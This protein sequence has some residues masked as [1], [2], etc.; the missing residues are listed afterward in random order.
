MCSLM[1]CTDSVELALGS[2]QKR[3]SQELPLSIHACVAETCQS[4]TLDAHS[5][6]LT[7]GEFDSGYMCIRG[8]EQQVRLSFQRFPRTASELPVTLTIHAY[9]GTKLFEGQKTATIAPFYPNGYECDKNNP[10]YSGKVD[11]SSPSP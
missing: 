9:D 2:P 6:E 5:C 4:W 7:T 11:F 3:Y 1:G 8:G 10:C